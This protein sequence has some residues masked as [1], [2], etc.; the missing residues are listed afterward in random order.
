MCAIFQLVLSVRYR[1]RLASV[2]F[3]LAR[4]DSSYVATATPNSGICSIRSVSNI[5]FCIHQGVSR[6]VQCCGSCNQ[7]RGTLT[8]AKAAAVLLSNESCSDRYGENYCQQ[9]INPLNEW[10]L[11]KWNCVGF[12]PFMAFRACRKTCGFCDLARIAYTLDAALD[13]CKNVTDHDH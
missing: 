8:Y 10:T 3:T 6:F 12:N 7:H 1:G 9:Y 2:Y 4:D 11:R 5:H 13:S